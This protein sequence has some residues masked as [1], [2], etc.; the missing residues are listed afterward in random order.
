MVRSGRSDCQISRI[1]RWQIRLSWER[2]NAPTANRRERRPGKRYSVVR[3]LTRR[4]EVR[5]S[6]RIEQQRAEPRMPG[7]RGKD[8]R[9]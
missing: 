3:Q 1:T 8:R 5:I 2:K 9:R 7:N 4:V 6:G